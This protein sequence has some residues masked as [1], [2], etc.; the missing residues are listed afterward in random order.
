M[1]VEEDLRRIDQQERRLRPT[2]FGPP[3]AWALGLR[4]KE[5]AELRAAPVAIDISMRDRTLF[6]AALLGSTTDNAEW[7]RRKRNTVL[8]LWCSSYAAGLRLQLAGA[9]QEEKYALDMA[10]YACHGGSFPIVLEGTGCIG[11]VT[12]SGLPQRQ[13]HVLVV[14]VLAEFLGVDIA[15]CRLE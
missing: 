14:D 4:L 12:I 2:R 13:D 7:I 3:E 8:R 11:A 9:T 10:N 5:T 6:H 15:D 1:S